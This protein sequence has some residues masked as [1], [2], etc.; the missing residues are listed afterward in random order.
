MREDNEES[1]PLML[2][3]NKYDIIEEDR[4]NLDETMTMD[5]L[6]EF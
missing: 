3:V 6:R 4:S 2:V 1:I 5:F